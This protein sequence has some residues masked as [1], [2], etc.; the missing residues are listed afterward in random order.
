MKYKDLRKIF[1]ISA[2]KANAAFEERIASEDALRLALTI[3]GN[4]AFC[5]VNSEEYQ[6]IVRAERLDKEINRLVAELP[7]KAIEQY[8]INC[9]IDEL[10]LTNEIEGVN[11][12]RREIGEILD[13]LERSDRR[14]RFQGIAEKY[15]ALQRGE[16]IALTTCADVRKVYDDLVLDEVVA[17]NPKNAPDGTYF[18]SSGVDVLDATQNPY[19]MASNRKT[20]SFRS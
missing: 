14:G 5:L 19:T 16:D 8:T 11:S 7:G 3:G 2:D 20:S 1:H 18:R 4:D 6:L 17:R 9:L 10:V 12:S 15:L 13:R